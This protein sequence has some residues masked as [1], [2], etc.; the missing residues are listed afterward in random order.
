[1]KRSEVNDYLR[2]ALE[3]FQGHRFH[4]PPFAHWTPDDWRRRRLEAQ[5]IS[6]RRLG[7]DITDFGSGNFGQCGLLLFTLRNGYPG[8][9]EKIFAEK[10]MIVRENQ[11]TPFHFHFQKTED[12]IN[13]GGGRLV[14]E[15]YNSDSAGALA[16]GQVRVR[17]DGLTRSVAGGGKI[18]LDPGESITLVPGVYHSFY[19]AQGHALVGEVSSVND[20]ATDNRFE[21]AL[22]RFST[23]EE[24]EAP[25][26]LLCSDYS[27][28][29]GLIT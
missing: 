15:L 11:R 28:L 10:I 8:D 4:L 26:R 22:P 3:F 2:Q 9:G 25:L 19:A 5:Y 6:T 18:T 27:H 12:I 14:V 24:D 29:E 23:I 7:W 21:Q 17:C 20:D 13:R 1:M 16:S